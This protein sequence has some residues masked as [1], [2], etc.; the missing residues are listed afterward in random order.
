MKTETRSIGDLTGS[1]RERFSHTDVESNVLGVLRGPKKKGIA[2]CKNEEE[3][4]EDEENQVGQV[5][6]GMDARRLARR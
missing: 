3:E 1:C 2:P 6:S 4:D 5:T